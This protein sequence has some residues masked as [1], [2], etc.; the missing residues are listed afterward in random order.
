MGLF[1]VGGC[2]F[3]S[4]SDV[5]VVVEEFADAIA[6]VGRMDRV[7]PL[8]QAVSMVRS[9]SSRMPVTVPRAPGWRLV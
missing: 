5:T 2:R 4:W 1:R 3:G 8:S 6:G 9:G 7:L